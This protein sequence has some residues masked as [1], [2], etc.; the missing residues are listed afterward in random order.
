MNITYISLL[1]VFCV[2][3]ASADRHHANRFSQ[4]K[5]E[6]LIKEFDRTN[7]AK[8]ACLTRQRNQSPWSRL[9][10][11]CISCKEEEEAF[12]TAFA[13]LKEEFRIALNKGDLETVG[14][15][16]TKINQEDI[17]TTVEMLTLAGR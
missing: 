9:I 11:G 4:S 1:S 16:I 2:G 14:L 15:L 8:L 17:D 6:S 10:E 5:A 3:I 7:Q 12:E 13:E